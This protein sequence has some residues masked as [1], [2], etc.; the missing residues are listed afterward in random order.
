MEVRGARASSVIVHHIPPGATNVFL[1]WQQGVSA[2]AAEFPGY[3]TT[4]VYP[5]ASNDEGVVVVH[6]DDANTLQRW[7]DSPV[8]ADW[9]AKLPQEIRDFHLKTLPGGFA[10]WFVGL[11]DASQPL[12]HWKM[13]LTVLLA[14]YPTVMLLTIF[15]VPHT[16]RFGLAV[17][18]LIGNAASVAFL[19]WLAMPF[20]NRALGTWLRANTKETQ[21]LSLVG[22]AI[23]LASLVTMA[24]VFNLV[25]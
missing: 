15:L 8:R 23:I 19:E 17:A 11:P 20:L 21:G 1:A 13:Y 10:S 14:L 16:S 3:Q 6:F 18:M 12:P 2:A 22:M 24:L 5:P 4:E 9:I 25:T 7:L